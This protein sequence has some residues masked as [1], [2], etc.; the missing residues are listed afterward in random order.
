MNRKCSKCNGTGEIENP[1]EVGATMRAKRVTGVQVG[2]GQT[3]RAVA[4]KMGFTASYIC[5]LEQGRRAWSE[6]LKKAYL[7]ALEF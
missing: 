3:L 7:K 6:S 2:N 1:I 5:D 4:R